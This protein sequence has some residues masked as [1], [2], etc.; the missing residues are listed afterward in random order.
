MDL[1]MQIKACKRYRI[2]NPEQKSHLHC[3]QSLT[4]VTLAPEGQV[5]ISLESVSWFH[6][7]Q[8]KN[9]Q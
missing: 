7:D 5:F 6:S 1:L 2:N 9:W 4:K 3:I 8:I